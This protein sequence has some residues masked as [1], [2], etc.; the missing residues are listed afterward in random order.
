MKTHEVT[1]FERLQGV[2]VNAGFDPLERMPQRRLLDQ[3]T[4]VLR[5]TAEVSLRT[6]IHDRFSGVPISNRQGRAFD[7]ARADATPGV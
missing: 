3:A 2:R 5:Q 4:N 1:G 7:G 6:L